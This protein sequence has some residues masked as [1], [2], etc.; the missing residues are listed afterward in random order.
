[1]ATNVINGTDLIVFMD[2]DGVPTPVAH[3]TTYTLT[4]T[5]ATRPTTNKGSGQIDEKGAGRLDVTGTCTSL[6]VYG[7]YEDLVNAHIA[8][9]PVTLSFGAVINTDELDVSKPYG[10]GDFLINS[11]EMNAPDGENST[12]TMTFEHAEGFEYNN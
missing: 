10:Q 6:M 11:L 8:G 4:I 7:S 3:G 9:D 12:Y 2:V 1:M 5:M